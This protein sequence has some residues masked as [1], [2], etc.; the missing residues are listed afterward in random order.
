M[1]LP[2]A[3]VAVVGGLVALTDADVITDLAIAESMAMQHLAVALVN[4]A[5]QIDTAR[6]RQDDQ[7]GLEQEPPVNA[8]QVDG[9]AQTSHGNRVM[10]RELHRPHQGSS[11]SSSAA[12]GRLRRGGCSR[13]IGS[14][15]MGSTSMGSRWGGMAR[16]DT[17]IERRG[18][19]LSLIH[20]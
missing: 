18:R 20:I 1:Q 13:S 16:R 19:G 14:T 17:G 3:A 2:G 4:A 10:T 11:R 6:T 9:L 5:L 7:P 8:A 15:S 12:A